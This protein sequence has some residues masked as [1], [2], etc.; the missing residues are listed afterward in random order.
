MVLRLKLVFS[1]GK[2][3]GQ[4]VLGLIVVPQQLDHE[5]VLGV[6]FKTRKAYR[7]VGC[8]LEQ[9]KC[10]QLYD[11]VGDPGGTLM[12]LCL[13][14]HV[15]SLKLNYCSCMTRWETLEAD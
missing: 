3:E 12:L 8:K 9:S 6:S 4:F 15:C 5:K 2:Y 14:V 10:L 11:P 7:E 1:K 13:L